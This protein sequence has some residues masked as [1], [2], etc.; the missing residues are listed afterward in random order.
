MAAVHQKFLAALQRCA[1]DPERRIFPVLDGAQF[2]DL[3][4]ELA[5]LGVAH[6]SLYRSVQ[7][8]ELLRVG[9]WVVNPYRYLSPLANAW[10]GMPLG[11]IEPAK[12]RLGQNEAIASDA[13]AALQLDHGVEI[14]S[15]A[16]G[17]LADPNEQLKQLAEL[18]GEMPAAVFWVG[19]A[20]FS[21]PLLWRHLRHLNMVLIPQETAF[22]EERLSDGAQAG[23][24]EASRVL[25]RHADANVMAQ[26]LPSLSPDQ[27]ATVLGPASTVI[28]APS[29]EWSKGAG[30]LVAPRPENGV[31]GQPG[32]LRL[33]PENIRL[34]DATRRDVDRARLIADVARTSGNT[35]TSHQAAQAFDRAHSYGLRTPE[36]VRQFVDLDLIYGAGFEDTQRFRYAAEHL[37]DEQMTSD[38]KL[39][40]VMAEIKLLGAE[41]RD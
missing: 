30:F 3:P 12:N 4:S 5:K 23:G 24:G 39:A 35:S 29:A 1:D 34:I 6:R 32:G 31:C 9:P 13:R 10:G 38:A 28:F 2:A 36:Q 22:G 41:G 20:Q 15:S 21:E 7:D 18:L 25:F 27:L 8:V 33:Y 19:G 17:R 37:R 14:A 16:D 26:V 40:C 11:D